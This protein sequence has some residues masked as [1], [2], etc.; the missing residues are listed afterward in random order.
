M[1][2]FSP[3]H[4]HIQHWSTKMKPFLLKLPPMSIFTQATVQSKKETRLGA[5]TRQIPFQGK[6]TDGEI[7][8]AL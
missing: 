6:M 8:S 3:Q 2:K 1:I 4:W 5:L 7:R